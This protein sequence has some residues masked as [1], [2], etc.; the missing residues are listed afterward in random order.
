M[1]VPIPLPAGRLHSRWC[2]NHTPCMSR[3][4][5]AGRHH[6]SLASSAGWAACPLTARPAFCR[7]SCC[8]LPRKSNTAAGSAV[9]HR[10]DVKANGP[11]NV[12]RAKWVDDQCPAGGAWGMAVIDRGAENTSLM[13]PSVRYT[14][15]RTNL[16]EVVGRPRRSTY[17]AAP[18]S[19]V[20]VEAS[21]AS[22]R[23][24]VHCRMICRPSASCIRRQP[25]V[26]AAAAQRWARSAR[27]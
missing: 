25:H 8:R 12:A 9:P 27:T 14:T 19:V 22:V 11:G 21:S 10:P 1:W 13:R 4:A 3:R 15:R 20:Q 18:A 7:V 6:M 17:T 26:P 23:R 16:M 24:A 5:S 2:D